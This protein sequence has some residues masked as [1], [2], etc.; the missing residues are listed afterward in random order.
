M[1]RVLSA[2]SLSLACKC[3]AAALIKK[4]WF[5]LPW[6]LFC[7][8]EKK[9]LYSGG[10]CFFWLWSCVKQTK[11][12]SVLL[13][14]DCSDTKWCLDVFLFFFYIFLKCSTKHEAC[15]TYFSC[16]HFTSV[17]SL[18]SLTNFPLPLLSILLHPPSLSPAP[19]LFNLCTVSLLLSLLL[20]SLITVAIAQCSPVWK[21]VSW[22]GGKGDQTL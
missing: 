6:N 2:L 13:Y 12:F 14:E 8:W 21:C 3:S 19:S 22:R 16:F 15:W 5:S 20:Q 11:Q 1:D 9:G 18:F 17:P 4:M 7:V 10:F